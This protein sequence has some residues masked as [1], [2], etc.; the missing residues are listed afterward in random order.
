VDS[1]INILFDS[2]TAVSYCDGSTLSVRI[3]RLRLRRRYL[4]CGAICIWQMQIAPHHRR[5]TSTC[6]KPHTTT[7]TCLP[8]HTATS[9]T[10]NTP[11]PRRVQHHQ[12]DGG[13]HHHHHYSSRPIPNTSTT[14]SMGHRT[15]PDHNAGTNAN[16]TGERRT[17]QVE[18]DDRGQ[19]SRRGRSRALGM[20]SF[21]SYFSFYC[22]NDSFY[23][24]LGYDHDRRESDRDHLQHH[25]YHHHHH[26]DVSIPLLPSP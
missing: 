10:H 7:S 19:S 9:T 23:S 16:G 8:P 21:F 13:G 17:E 3:F 2:A 25:H 15:A 6:P 5:T 1:E 26:L 12:N 22:T 24:F 4:W 18:R 14:T 20:F 11:P